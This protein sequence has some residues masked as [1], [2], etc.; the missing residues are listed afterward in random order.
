MTVKYSRRNESGC[1]IEGCGLQQP[2]GLRHG[3]GSLDHQDTTY[4]FYC[5][6]RARLAMVPFP[7]SSID[8]WR[9]ALFLYLASTSAASL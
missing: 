3:R 5:Q 7:E 9:I 6:A 8:G 1:S 2:A 4:F